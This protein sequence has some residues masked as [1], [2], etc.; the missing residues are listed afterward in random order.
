MSTTTTAPATPANASWME[1]AAAVDELLNA[2]RIPLRTD[3]PAAEPPKSPPVDP[4]PAAPVNR[5]ALGQP[6]ESPKLAAP[7]NRITPGAPAEAPKKTEKP[8]KE[9]KQKP[10][11]VEENLGPD[12]HWGGYSGRGLLPSTATCVALVIAWFYFAVPALPARWFTPETVFGLPAAVAA[13]QIIRWGYRSMAMNYRVT[14]QKLV[15]HRGRLYGRP[16][17]FDLAAIASVNVKQSFLGRFLG[18]GDVQ[19]S[20]DRNDHSPVTLECVIQP[21]RLASLLEQTCQCAREGHVVAKRM[22]TNT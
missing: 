3:K 16:H 4:K 1:A 15:Y 13:F 22:V 14:T 21:R 12:I 9:K 19:V 17:V 11:P 10:P 18:V 7:V 5:V 20:F 2:E 8:A 6:A